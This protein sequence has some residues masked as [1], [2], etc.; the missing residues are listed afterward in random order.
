MKEGMITEVLNSM[1]ISPPWRVRLSVQLGP[2]PLTVIQGPGMGPRC[3]PVTGVPWVAL[4]QVE[5]VVAET[6]RNSMGL[7][8]EQEPGH[9]A[10]RLC[11]YYFRNNFFKS[12]NGLNEIISPT[13]FST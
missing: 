11:L 6:L 5:H 1:C 12:V 4:M 7:T 8:L 3:P 9:L 13:L 2:L 10:L